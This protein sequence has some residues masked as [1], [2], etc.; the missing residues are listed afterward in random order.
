MHD[1]T[2]AQPLV[3]QAEKRDVERR[4]K[5]LSAARAT[6]PAAGAGSARAMYSTGR[7]AS[8]VILAAKPGISSRRIAALSASR[9]AAESSMRL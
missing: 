8:A 1:P 3:A 9:S 5:A 4:V 6:T 2:A 7:P